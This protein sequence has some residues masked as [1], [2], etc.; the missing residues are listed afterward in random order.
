MQSQ[1]KQE[2]GSIL[3]HD[4]RKVFFRSLQ[5]WQAINY[6]FSNHHYWPTTHFILTSGAPTPLS[7]SPACGTWADGHDETYWHKCC[8]SDMTNHWL[9]YLGSGHFWS[10]SCQVWAAPM[11]RKFFF[12][13]S[14]VCIFFF[15]FFFPQWIKLAAWIF[16]LWIKLNEPLEVEFI[17]QKQSACLRRPHTRSLEI[18][19][20]HL[21]RV[22]RVMS[23]HLRVAQKALGSWFR[24][25]A[26]ADHIPVKGGG[27]GGKEISYYT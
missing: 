24:V 27:E 16:Y 9:Y 18:D 12:F 17:M 20:S 13:W 8:D 11:G 23:H 2:K 15:H 21:H 6:L 22:R 26:L 1:G 10:R 19:A 4:Y 5:I 25:F 3:G 14:H 7:G